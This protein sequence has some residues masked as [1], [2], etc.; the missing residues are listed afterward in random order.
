MAVQLRVEDRLHCSHKF[1]TWK[2][3]ITRILD[4]SDAEEHIDSTKVAPTDPADL[5]AWKKIDSRAM[6]IIMDGV[7]DHI[8]PH[9]SG[10][11]ITVEMWT[12]LE[13]LYQSKNEN[14]KMV[15]QKRGCAAP[16][17]PREE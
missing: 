2:E 10:T 12:A 17:W 16:K 4:V 7:K 3:R 9:L 8:V 6:L 11:K 14:R 15:L 5:A 13:S 1:P